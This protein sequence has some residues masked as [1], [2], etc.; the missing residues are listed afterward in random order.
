MNISDRAISSIRTA[1]P[2]IAGYLIALIFSSLTTI[3]SRTISSAVF[4][5]L[6]YEIAR[7]G[8]SKG[9]RF[10]SF[11]LGYPKEPIYQIDTQVLASATSDGVFD[12][13]EEA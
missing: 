1:T 7:T 12:Y 3:G 5:I 4:A 9:V 10:C 8:E 13:Y 11:M 2:I 6:Y